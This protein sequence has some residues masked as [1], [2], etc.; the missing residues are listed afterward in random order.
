MRADDECGA[1]SGGSDFVNVERGSVAGEDG[2]GFADAIEFLEDFFLQGHAF[3]DGFDD[4]I[5]VCEIVV[6]RAWA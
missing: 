4:Q 5:R 3:E 2:A 6:A 1:R